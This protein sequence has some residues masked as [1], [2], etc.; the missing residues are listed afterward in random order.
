MKKKGKNLSITIKKDEDLK[1]IALRLKEV[2]YPAYILWSIGIGTGF[3][4]GDLVKLTVGDIREAIPKKKISI[5]EEKTKNKRKKKFEREEILPNK[6]I[7]IL[8]DYIY[9]K[10]DAAYLYPAP[11]AKGRG[12]LK[13][14][15]RRD[16]LGKIF[17]GVVE[18][19]GICKKTDAVGTHTPRKSYGYKQYTTHERDIRFV[20]KLFGHSKEETTSDY[21]GLNDDMAESAAKTMNDCIF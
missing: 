12:E 20:Q 11:R 10:S 8:E 5:L 21:I 9:G 6:L 2:D 1:R 7:K 18:E 16:R 15:I 17:R 13:E 3:R 14:H 4:G 19:L